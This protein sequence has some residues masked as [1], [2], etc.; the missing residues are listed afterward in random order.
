MNKV[1]NV[2]TFCGF[3]KEFVDFLISLQFNNTVDMLHENTLIYKR[4]ITEPLTLLFHA[5]IQPALSVSGSLITK[6][7]KCVSTMYNDMRF[8]ASTP[9]KRYM[10]IRFRESE[11]EKDVLGLYFDMGCDYYSYGIRI[12]KQTCAGMEK[13]RENVIN[14]GRA[15]SLELDKLHKIGMSI[16]GDSYAKDRYP[17]INDCAV[18]EFLNK[19]NFYIGRKCAINESVFDRRLN[20]EVS[21]TFLEVKGFYTLLKKSMYPC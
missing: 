20:D 7:S 15:F 10:Y 5:L 6:P 3:P 17:T 12:Y 13:I 16:Y 11:C 18:K 14:N 21:K 8:S 4:L 1:L 19:K 2:D 9:L